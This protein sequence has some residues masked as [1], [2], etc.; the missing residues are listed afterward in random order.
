MRTLYHISRCAAQSKK[1]HDKLSVTSVRAVCDPF[2]RG[3]VFGRRRLAPANRG[4]S[5][6]VAGSVPRTK[7]GACPQDSCEK[8]EQNETYPQDLSKI[9]II[10]GE[11]WDGSGGRARRRAPPGARE[12]VLARSRRR[13]TIRNQWSSP[14]HGRLNQAYCLSARGV[15]T[16]KQ[17]IARAGWTAA[18]QV[19]PQGRTQRKR[20]ENLRILDYALQSAK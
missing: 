18:A 20:R 13:R 19:P 12:A 7:N 14:R 17:R 1:I 3:V 4:L 5:P 15:T 11:S 2:Q 9:R 6:R 8:L 16:P 10:C